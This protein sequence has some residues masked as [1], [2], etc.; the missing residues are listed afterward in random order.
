MVKVWDIVVRAGHWILVVAFAIAYVTEGEPRWL[1]S[2]AGYAIGIVLIL[3]IVW[4]FA[5]PQHARFAD[6]VR[7]PGAV[8]RY[9]A[10]LLRFRAPRF[11]GHSPAGGAMVVALILSLAASAVTGTMLLAVRNGEGPLAP[12]LYAGAGTTP[13]AAPGSGDRSSTDR[14][15]ERRGE[16]NRPGRTLKQIH[17]ILANVSLFLVM[18]HLLGVALASI[19]H[20][21]NLVRAMITGWKSAEPGSTPPR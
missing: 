16:R 9:L 3:R 1:H 4:G 21:E 5:G 11:V 6:F 7:G 19:A 14:A 10:G 15:A 20:R 2:W 12:W 8:L 18:L 13:I 17:E